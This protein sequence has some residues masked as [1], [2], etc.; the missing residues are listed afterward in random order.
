MSGFEIAGIVLGVIPLFISAAE[1][2][3]N[4]LNTVDKFLKKEQILNLYIQE[5]ETHKVL[6]RLQLETVIGSTNLPAK[7]QQELVDN[8][9]S[10][11]WQHPDVQAQLRQNLGDTADLLQK[12][13]KRMADVFIRQ[14]DTDD[15]ISGHYQVPIPSHPIGGVG[16]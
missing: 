6:L 4:G 1:Q 15:T 14:I 3:R 16:G 13:M 2:Y 7:T 5:L 8:T 10:P 11:L 9:I 12:T